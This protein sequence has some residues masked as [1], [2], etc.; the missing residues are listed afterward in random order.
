[1]RASNAP[2]D[3]E[4]PGQTSHSAIV[5]ELVSGLIMDNLNKLYIETSLESAS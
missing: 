5:P 3:G 4:R 2:L 1:M